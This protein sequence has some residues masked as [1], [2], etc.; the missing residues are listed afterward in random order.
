VDE[1]LASGKAAAWVARPNVLGENINESNAFVHGDLVEWLRGKYA[2]HSAFFKIVGH[3]R[4]RDLLDAN[5][6]ER[7]DAILRQEVA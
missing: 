1:I 7:V 6:L 4:R 5:I 3:P 2:V